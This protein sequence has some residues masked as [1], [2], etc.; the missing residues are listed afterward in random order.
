MIKFEVFL[1]RKINENEP[2]SGLYEISDYIHDLQIM[3]ALKSPY[4]QAT[5]RAKIPFNELP[6]I[7]GRTIPIMG[8]L[9]QDYDTMQVDGWATIYEIDDEQNTRKLRFFGVV[10]SISSGIVADQNGLKTTIDLNITLSSWISVLQTNIKLILSEYY[11]A[12]GLDI[13]SGVSSEL[14]YYAKLNSILQNFTD[15]KDAIKQWYSLFAVFSPDSRIT[16][17]SL[18]DV[19]FI[20]RTDDLKK[21]AIKG[22]TLTEIVSFNFDTLFPSINNNILSSLTSSFQGEMESV[23]EFFPSYE[24]VSSNEGIFSNATEGPPQAQV[25]PVLIYRY[26]PIPIDYKNAPAAT[27]II[28]NKGTVKSGEIRTNEQGQPQLEFDR[29]GGSLTFKSIQPKLLKPLKID[30]ISSLSI[31]WSAS[32]RLNLI[33]VSTR[34]SGVNNILGTTTDFFIDQE[35]V[36][37][38]GVFGYEA[39]YPFFGAKQENDKI[40]EF[41]KELTTYV[42]LLFGSGEIYGIAQC[43]SYYEP[44]IKHGEYVVIGV[45]YQQGNMSN[46]S[47]YYIGYCTQVTHIHK[48][49][50]DGRIQRST[51]FTLERLQVYQE[52]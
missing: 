43:V 23:I 42:R 28:L 24:E 34:A 49:L 20:T 37:K 48:A 12:Q 40:R 25:Q 27:N 30:T 44:N 29:E 1:T 10:S 50:S 9:L 15:P 11:K 16:N 51:S 36:K 46:P 4:E 3:Y 19:I 35:S 8:D 52:G 18:K 32:N 38:Y 14:A 21:H 22:R 17:K 26:R 31:T 39:T 33:N 6:I 5:L 7:F 45:S 2:E 13:D 47:N 41:A